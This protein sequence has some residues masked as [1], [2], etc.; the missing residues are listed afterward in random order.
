MAARTD[1]LSGGHRSADA[2]TYSSSGNLT[3]IDHGGGVVS[4]HAHQSRIGIRVGQQ[5]TAGQVVGSVGAT[6]NVTGPHLHYE[7][8]V[9]GT[10][11]NPR[12]YLP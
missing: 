2:A 7:V 12:R 3:L 4:A 8:R 9:G 11:R 6:G 5:V 1:Q 10:A